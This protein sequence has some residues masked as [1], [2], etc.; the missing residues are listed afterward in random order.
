[1]SRM[2][3]SSGIPAIGKVSADPLPIDSEAISSPH[4]KSALEVLDAA[5]SGSVCPGR[6]LRRD[7]HSPPADPARL[8]L[9]LSASFRRNDESCCPLGNE[10]ESVQN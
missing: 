5:S 3:I 2:T 9:A 8:V 10:P 1:M 6:Q 4:A 7:L